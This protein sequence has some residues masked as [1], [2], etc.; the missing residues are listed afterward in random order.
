MTL[1]LTLIGGRPKQL[2]PS[3][4]TSML[5][6]AASLS[7]QQ[8][9]TVKEEKKGRLASEIKALGGEIPSDSQSL[10]LKALEG[11]LRKAKRDNREDEAQLELELLCLLQDTDGTDR[12]HLTPNFH[13]WVTNAARV[14]NGQTHNYNLVAKGNLLLKAM[15]DPKQLKYPNPKF[16]NPNPP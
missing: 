1:T 12:L 15:Q 6:L 10:S 16:P 11:L 8:S 7:S 5:A 2:K 4:S 13:D 3:V 9:H 14:V